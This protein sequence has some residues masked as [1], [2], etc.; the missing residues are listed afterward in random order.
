[1][2]SL[3]AMF[4]PSSSSPPPPRFPPPP[5]PPPWAVRPPPGNCSFASGRKRVASSSRAIRDLG[6]ELSF[7]FAAVPS[8]SF[9]SGEGIRCERGRGSRRRRGRGRRGI[10]VVNRQ[11]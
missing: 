6:K 3:T 2:R 10:R 1:T 4:G 9:R 11:R 5:P 7:V 8:H